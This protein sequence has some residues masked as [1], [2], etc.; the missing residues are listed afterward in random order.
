MRIA[1][2]HSTFATPGGAER[3]VRDLSRD[4]VA[5]GHEVRI[6][7]RGTSRDDDGDQLVPTRLSARIP[8][9]PRLRLVR[10]VA[11]HLGDLADPTGIGPRD[12]SDF[13]PDLVHLHNWQGLGALPVARLARRYPTCHT[14]HDY[15]ICDPNNSL[16]HGYRPAPLASLL[17]LR[18]AWLVWQLRNVTPLWPAERARD[19][20]R[21]RVPAAARLDGRIIPLAVRMTPRQWPTGSQNVFIYL[22]ALSPHKGTSLML[23]AWRAVAGEI[24]A[25]LLI[26]G[27]GPQRAEVEAA[28]HDCPSI[29][30]LG[31]L[32]EAG[33]VRAM[34]EA[35]WLVYPSQ[36]PETFGVSA[37]E[38]LVAGR[39]IIAD[40]GARP[41]TASDTSLVTFRNREEFSAMLRW[42]VGIPPERYR[43][44]S[45]SAA[46]D[47]RRVDWDTHVAAIER[48]YE[49]LA[50]RSL[51]IHGT[52]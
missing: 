32:D 38:S 5:R 18:S 25:T 9:S 19:I 24:D 15:A 43:Q 16:V 49:E 34:S 44:M 40:A 23:D 39:P 29:R 36:C 48:T 3:Y 11:T 35:G 31:Y 30:Y 47:G 13:Q 20:V 27:D 4:L 45:A 51:A 26:A 52:R 22:G 50:G 28:A 14:V 12:L 2:V 41:V 42:A 33:K 37:V 10:K 7:C 6:F 1:M 17:R 46:G 21:S 8:A